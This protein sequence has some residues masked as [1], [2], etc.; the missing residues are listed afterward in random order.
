VRLNG[1][2]LWLAM[3][4][5]LALCSSGCGGVNANQSVSPATFFLPGLMKAAPPATNSPVAL[6][7]PPKEVASSR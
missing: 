3:L 5:A 7:E 4:L 1:N 6:P 2:F